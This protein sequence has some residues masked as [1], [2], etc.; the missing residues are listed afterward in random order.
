MDKTKSDKLIIA[1]CSFLIMLWL[2]TAGSKLI[3]IPMY[4]RGLYG[5]PFS[6]DLKDFLFYALPLSEFFLITLLYFKKTRKLGYLGSLL[7]LT[8]FTAYIILVLMGYYPKIPCSCGGILT[9]MS[10]K[11]HLWFNI[12]CIGISAWLTLQIQQKS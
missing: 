1:G 10:W 5:Q 3:D 7:L 8:I 4:K 6:K 12:F 2:Y 9:M 11:V